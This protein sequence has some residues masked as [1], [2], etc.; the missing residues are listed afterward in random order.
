MSLLKRHANPPMK[1]FVVAY[2][3]A[4]QD[5]TLTDS[6]ASRFQQHLADCQQCRDWVDRQE[7][8]IEYLRTE[9][10]PRFRLSPTASAR[11]QRN[12]YNRMRR[13]MLMNN[14]KTSVGAV[15][16]V[17]VLAIIVGFFALQ[18]GNFNTIDSAAGTP[19]PTSIPPTLN[20]ISI[21]LTQQALTSTPIPPPSELDEQLFEAVAA[22]DTAAVEK[23][24][25]AGANPNTIN[26][27]GLPV[28]LRAIRGAWVSGNT[29]IVKMLLEF[30][31]DVNEHN[32]SDFACLPQAAYSG[33]LEVVQI[34]LDAGADVNATKSFI[35]RSG[36]KFF[37][38]PALLHA[39]DGNYIEVV[40]LLLAY[41][42][43]VNQTEI[44]YKGHALF[45][46]AF[47]NYPEMVTL[48]L[49]N[50]AD[51]SMRT[52]WETGNTALHGAAFNGSVEAAQ[53]LLDGGA[54][55]DVQ[56]DTGLTPLM[57][58]ISEGIHRRTEI[59]TT[60]LE[61]G[62]DPNAQDNYG[63]TALHHAARW[64]RSEMIPLLIEY[65]ASIDLQDNIGY[66]ALHQ[67][68]KWDKAGALSTLLEHGASLD[69]KNSRGQTALGVALDDRI[70]EILREAGA[71][72]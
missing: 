46:A 30:G 1:H 10:S 55:V 4:F 49:D 21:A 8:L 72:E 7:N 40:E 14:I 60:L 68:A 43:D 45:S 19:E 34:L 25:N 24:L 29:D 35:A 32:G 27:D 44:A 12:L 63:N 47:Y 22:K 39:V 64:D 42:A 59:V 9:A 28:L 41:G 23:F 31:A 66:T 50:G 26:A 5:G 71:E 11:V 51:P 17:A 18:A 52:K 13:A 20:S 62:A 6:E 38:A 65:G 61:G 33:Q 67:A 2:F 58:A 57:Y 53:A 56:T 15:T 36:A 70:I 69:L 54:D 16:A 3:E 37:Q 48:L